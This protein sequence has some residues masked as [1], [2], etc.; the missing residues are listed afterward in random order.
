LMHR[1]F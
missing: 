1:M